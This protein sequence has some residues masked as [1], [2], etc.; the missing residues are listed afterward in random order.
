MKRKLSRLSLVG[1]A[2]MLGAGGAVA[3]APSVDNGKQLFA[4]CAACHAIDRS[5]G[6]GPHL[7]GIVDRPA[8][9]VEG[10]R[11]S[12][13]LRSAGFNWDRA[14]LDA[15]IADPQKGLPGNVMPYSGLADPKD[16]ADLI[17]Y[18]ATLK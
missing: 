6:L 10:F 18:L 2:L 8:G 3:Q 7:N 14:R 1:S 9:S 16:R 12:R 17:A 15:Y 11:Y 5:N 13:V 4:A